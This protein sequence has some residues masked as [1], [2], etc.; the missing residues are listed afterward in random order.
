MNYPIQKTGI[1]L[2][3]SLL[4]F[5]SVRSQTTEDKT[6]SPYFLVLSDDPSVDQ[7]PLKS[8]SA[9]VNIVGVIADVSITQVYRNEGK[10]TLEAIYTFPASTKAAV[11]A[12]EMHIGT[13]TIIAKIEERQKARAAYQEAKKQGKRASLLEQQRP[14][15]FQM[16]VANIMPGDEIV[17][18]LKYSELLVPEKGI[19]QFVYPTVTGPRYTGGS[20]PGSPADGFT[21]VP[22]QHEGEQPFYEFGLKVSLSSGVPIQSVDCPS[23]KILVSYPSAGQAII[24]LDKSEKN[25]GNRDFVLNYSL[26]GEQIASGVMLYEHGDENFFL[27]MIQ[28]PASVKAQ[29]IPPREYI[30]IVDVSG[31][32]RGFPLQTSKKLIRDL[33]TNLRPTDRFN[34]LLFA[35]TSGWLNKEPVYATPA[36]I[37]K[38]LNVID[39]QHGSGGTE[40]LPALKKALS[41]PRAGESLSRSIVIVTDGYVTVEREAFDLIRKNSNKANVF[42]FGIGSSVNRFL[43]EGMAHAGQGEPMIV[44]DP[45]KA[46]RQAEK[47]RQYINRP[48]LTRIKVDF[49]NFAVY[50]VD[51]EAVAD[52]LAER[53]V[54]IIG[55]YSGK[56]R[57]HITIK[58]FTGNRKYKADLDVETAVPDKR[59]V[60]IR[61]LWAREKIRRMDDY[62]EFSKRKDDIK[63]IT[64]LG[65][66]YN[67]MTAY[68]SFIAIDEKEVID[69]TGQLV[70]VKQA[71]PLPK[72][73]PNTA[74]GFDGGIFKI[75]CN[76]TTEEDDVEFEVSGNQ[77]IVNTTL[78]GDDNLRATKLI[79]EKLLNTLE[80]CFVPELSAPDEI[81]I[82]VGNDGKIKDVK[83]VGVNLSERSRQCI[84][85]EVLKWDLTGLVTGTEWKIQIYY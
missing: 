27:A 63:E 32:M 62:G 22:Y 31:S 15:I 73:V 46:H 83:I 20:N 13:R 28:P 36:N 16:N 50:N 42:V 64:Q 82:V 81:E 85:R 78:S 61:Y 72:G 79:E 58:G 75:V 44:S 49:G 55:K 6:L 56:S 14:N 77:P 48:V 54:I 8:T 39:Y 67:L 43:I 5:T 53:P 29:D 19:Y 60:A 57:G 66:K 2:L 17:V 33:V 40:L 10:K 41:M 76:E 4:S 30:F 1:V 47:F 18:Q 71:L 45:S 59:N 7:L 52:V 37:D 21:S 65:L 34:V 23:H 35:G 25:G 24:E 9:E 84:R 11:Y 74:V 80:H 26:A 70:T 68:T 38:A 51:P 69:S 3:C 12:M